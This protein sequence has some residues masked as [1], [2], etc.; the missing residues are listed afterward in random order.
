[1]DMSDLK[2]AVDVIL[3]AADEWAREMYRRDDDSMTPSEQRLMEAVSRYRVILSP[4]VSPQSPN[5]LNPLPRPPSVPRIVVGRAPSSIQEY[6][7]RDT[8]V[9]PTDPNPFSGEFETAEQWDSPLDIE[10]LERTTVPYK[11]VPYKKGSR[12]R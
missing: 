10:A 7:T 5:P 3:K 8:D 1:M 9:P 4:Q 6:E 2:S 12:K 11:E